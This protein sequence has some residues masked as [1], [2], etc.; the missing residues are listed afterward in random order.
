MLFAHGGVK[1]SRRQISRMCLMGPPLHEEAIADAKEQTH[2]EHAGRETNPAPVVVVR[3]V[4]ALVQAVFDAAKTGPV[5]LQP[6]LGIQFLRFSAGEQS[7]V[8]VLAAVALA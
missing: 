8:L 3:D 2:N 5:E 4:Q 7:D 6:P 1:V